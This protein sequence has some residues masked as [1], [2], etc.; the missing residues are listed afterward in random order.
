[1]LEN[2]HGRG[3]SVTSVTQARSK[4]SATS[5]QVGQAAKGYPCRPIIGKTTNAGTQLHRPVRPG[6]ATCTGF[7][8]WNS[9]QNFTH[10]MPL[11]VPHPRV[12]NNQHSVL[13]PHI[14]A[15][16]AAV[17]LMG[18]HARREYRMTFQ[19]TVAYHSQPQQQS[20]Q[21]NSML[22]SHTC[23]HIMTSR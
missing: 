5:R 23:H 10:S 17:G 11:P 16:T 22:T 8:F 3:A 12:A 14:H 9:N 19:D 21:L 15:C 2:K 6:S 1:M 7:A 20:Q 18:I 4:Q 13:G